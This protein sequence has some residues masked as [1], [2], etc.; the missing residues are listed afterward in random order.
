G[1]SIYFAPNRATPTP[2]PPRTTFGLTVMSEGPDY[3]RFSVTGVRKGS[4]ADSLG[5][6]KGDLIAALD[7][8]PAAT[9]HVAEVRAALAE[10]GAHRTLVVQ[11]GGAPD[12]TFTFQVRVVSIED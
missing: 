11:R 6:H 2:F 5:F 7:G 4:P 10:A 9:W 3:T 12:T 1:S 8:K